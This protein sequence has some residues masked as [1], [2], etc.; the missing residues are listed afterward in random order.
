MSRIYEHYSQEELQDL[1]ESLQDC[2]GT[3][4]TRLEQAELIMLNALYHNQGAYS[5]VGQP[6]RNYFGMGRIE[7]LSSHQID[8]AEAFIDKHNLNKM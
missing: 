4:N 8:S 5:K 1:V 7:D 6:I 3:I 2:L